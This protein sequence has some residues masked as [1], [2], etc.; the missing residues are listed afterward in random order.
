MSVLVVVLGLAITT[1]AGTFF[2]DFNDGNADGWTYING[3]WRV[4]NNMLAQDQGGDVYKALVTDLQISS[5]SIA[6]QMYIGST[7]WPDWGG[8][9]GV[10][11]WYKDSNNWIDVIVYPWA[12]AINVT[13]LIDGVATTSTYSPQLY[14]NHIWY[15]LR[16]N[17]DAATGEVSVYIDNTYLFTY[18]AS[19]PYRTGLSG[20]NS[21]NAGGYFD[22]FRLTSN[23]I[24]SAPEPATMLLLGLGLLGLAG[25]RRKFKK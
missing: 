6:T 9:D 21:H 13:Q 4:E 19:T 15:D 14:G 3:N 24:A 22:N 23:D 2:D 11:I 1:Y 18:E 10:T 20:V 25:V 8:A 16:V 12:G 17:A 7:K 5:Q